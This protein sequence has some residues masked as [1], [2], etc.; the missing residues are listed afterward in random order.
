MKPCSTTARVP[1]ASAG[2][3]AAKAHY[4]AA[5]LTPFQEIQGAVTNLVVLDATVRESRQVIDDVQRLLKLATYRYRYG[6]VTYLDVIDAQRQVLSSERESV[7][8][9]REPSFSRQGAGWL[10]VG[11]RRAR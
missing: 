9:R 2:Y 7:A 1:F 3:E 6:M 4:R 5:A 10:L 8:R 11:A